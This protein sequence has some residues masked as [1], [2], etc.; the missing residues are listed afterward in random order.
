MEIF[1]LCRQGFD[2]S[3]ASNC[4][5]SFV[6]LL[7]ARLLVDD[8]GWLSDTMGVYGRSPEFVWGESSTAKEIRARVCQLTVVQIS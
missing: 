8:S 1:V 4:G 3:D 6:Y 5:L 7:R 2:C